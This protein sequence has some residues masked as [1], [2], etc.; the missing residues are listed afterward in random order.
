MAESAS[1]RWLVHLQQPVCWGL[2]SSVRGVFRQSCLSQLLSRRW[3]WP[4]ADLEQPPEGA[5]L[6]AAAC[7]ITPFLLDYD[8]M[9]LGVP[10]AWVATEAEHSGYLP[11]EKMMLAIAFLL[12][13]VARSLATWAHVPLAPLVLIALLGLVV[14]RVN[15]APTIL[16]RSL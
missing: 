10:L 4:T 16:A 13:L 2:I 7:L 12:P 5:T 3:P 11:W 14:R 15:V 6:A 8:L 9:L 1:Q